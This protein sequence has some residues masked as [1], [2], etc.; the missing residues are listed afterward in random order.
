MLRTR[1]KLFVEPVMRN[2]VLVKFSPH[3]M[4]VQCIGGVCSALGGV[5]C[6][7]GDIMSALGDIQCIGGIS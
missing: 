6:I 4:C 5:Q 2:T 1:P 3:I 7:G